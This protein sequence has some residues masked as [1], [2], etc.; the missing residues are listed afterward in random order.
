VVIWHKDAFQRNLEKLK[1]WA[2]GNI[3]RF[4]NKA[5][6]K[7]M[8]LRWGNPRYVYKLGEELLES[9]TAEND[10]GGLVDENLNMS[11]QYT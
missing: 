3:M 10:L 11:Q 7:V 1:R 4:N 5:K 2:L 9:S 6:C 8:H